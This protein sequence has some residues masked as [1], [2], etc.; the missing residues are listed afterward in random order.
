MNTRYGN[1]QAKK[2]TSQE[3][4]KWQLSKDKSFSAKPWIEGEEEGWQ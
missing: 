4:L 2:A 3:H 1:T